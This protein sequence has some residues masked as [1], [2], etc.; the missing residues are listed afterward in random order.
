M[1]QETE[2]HLANGRECSPSSFNGPHSPLPI[3]SDETEEDEGRSGLDEELA[4]EEEEEEE[5]DE[6]EEDEDEEEEEDE[7]EDA[8]GLLM[9]EED[10]ELREMEDY[11]SL[12][13]VAIRQR[14][15]LLRQAGERTGAARA[16]AAASP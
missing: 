16:R 13:P 15:Q 8:D 7:E 5:E 3:D 6:E 1:L 14:R 11:V 4:D 12:Q 2:T 9:F 10:A